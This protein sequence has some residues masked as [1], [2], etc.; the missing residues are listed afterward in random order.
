MDKIRIINLKIPGR[1]GVYDFDKNEDKIFEIDAELYLRLSDTGNSD[2]ISSTV[3]YGEVITSIN[4]VF[5]KKDCKL[6]E[7]VASSICDE[8]LDKY[9]VKKVRIRIRKPH[10]P[11]DANF[12]TIEV[13]FVRR[14]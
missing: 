11:I 13:E 9:P 3:D 1:H 12:D 5:R 10:A 8:L 14:K 4:D 2:D 6:I 7:T